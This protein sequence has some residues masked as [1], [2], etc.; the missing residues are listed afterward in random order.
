M[1]GLFITIEGTDGA[2]KSTQLKKLYDYLILNRFEVICVREPGGTVI[3]ER[4][5]EVIIDKELG[6]MDMM[7]EA[8]LYAASRS[9]LVK[10]VINPALKDGKVV[11]CDRFL[12][13]SIVYQGYARGLGTD[14]I[15]RINS[16]AVEDLQ[17][18][19]TFFLKLTPEEGILR[20]ENQKKLDRI[21]SE[22]MNFHKRVFDGYIN[23][24]KRNPQRIKS[25]DAR[26][27]Q[28]EVHQEIVKLFNLLIEE[29][30]L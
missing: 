18:D 15:K 22:S 11:L 1:S 16:Y 10:E 8:L 24:A 23:L 3:S 14:V 25:I 4:I 27:N 9:Q 21:E 17:P 2:G 30:S 20:K 12:D 26:K 29:R 28:E 19:I 6:Q 5:R 13:S 7:T